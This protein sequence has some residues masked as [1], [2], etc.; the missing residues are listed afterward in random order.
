MVRILLYAVALFAAGFASHAA[1]AENFRIGDK[2]PDFLGQ[3]YA[4]RP[5]RLSDDPARH[6]DYDENNAPERILFFDYHD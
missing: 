5:V 4:G 2:V 6:C 1:R 3:D